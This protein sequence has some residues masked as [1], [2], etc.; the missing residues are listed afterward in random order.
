MV[1]IEGGQRA[2]EGRTKGSQDNVETVV[3]TLVAFD[4][5]AAESK[6]V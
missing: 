4:V 1:V 2:E 3:R 6:I 5:V